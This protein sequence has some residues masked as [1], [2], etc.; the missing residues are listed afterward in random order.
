MKEMKELEKIPGND[1]E[2]LWLRKGE[3]KSLEEGK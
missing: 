2:N 1:Y 3:T